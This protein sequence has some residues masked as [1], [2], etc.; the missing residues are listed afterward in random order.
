M[1]PV[2]TAQATAIALGGLLGLGL[3][4]LVLAVPRWRR[5]S[6][7]ERLAP[8]LADVLPA[9]REALAA[10]RI[11]ILPVLG[12]LGLPV[13]AG[14][15]RL[16]GL[17]GTPTELGA[18]L[19]RAGVAPSIA[20]YQLQRLLAGLAGA[21]LAV[22]LGLPAL[23]GDRWALLP[24]CALLGLLAGL[25]GRDLLLRQQGRRRIE[26]LAGELPSV[27]ELLALSVAAGEAVPEA[28]RRVA[29]I[30]HG[31]IAAEL[32]AVGRQ[33]ASGVPLAAALAELA[34]RAGHP[35]LERALDH[36]VA[37]LDR[38]SP[39]AETLQAQAADVRVESR[40]TLLEAAGR[41]EVAMLLPL[42]FLILPATIAIAIFPGLMVLKLGFG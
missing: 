33:V 3:W 15:R 9:A 5:A 23:A 4:L 6:L 35:G 22:L 11:D 29:R 18:R 13:T 17:V 10:R 27:L 16:A 8:Q 36:L 7:T 42:V 32:G 26:Q 37:A 31:L 20:A 24:V 30:G 41:S 19:A 34:R 40:R 1:V 28:L 39:L 12:G 21:S 14:L 38:G 25:L 2:S